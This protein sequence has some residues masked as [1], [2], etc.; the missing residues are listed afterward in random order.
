VSDRY[1]L[2]SSGRPE[3]GVLERN[4]QHALDQVRARTESLTDDAYSAADATDWATAP[5]TLG[6]AVDRLAA[7]VAGLLGAPVP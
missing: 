1:Q 3:L 2:A 5:T 6:A 4:M 7:A